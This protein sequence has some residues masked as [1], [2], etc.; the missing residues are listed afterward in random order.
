[1]YSF[2]SHGMETIENINDSIEMNLTD[3]AFDAL[4]F[5]Q[6]EKLDLFKCTASIL[7]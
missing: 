2:T 3:A 6:E 1:M 5:K 4:N 7:H